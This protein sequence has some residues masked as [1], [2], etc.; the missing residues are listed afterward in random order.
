MGTDPRNKKSVPAYPDSGLQEAL[1]I[2]VA[3]SGVM[4]CPGGKSHDIPAVLI[5]SETELHNTMHITMP[6]NMH[7]K[8][9]AFLECIMNTS[10]IVRP[11]TTAQHFL[12]SVLGQM[13]EFM[14]QSPS[15]SD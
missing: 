11:A 14:T 12:A 1:W 2:M 3:S 5:L 15:K 10:A 13:S 8:A 6:C 9:Q 4:C 7:Y